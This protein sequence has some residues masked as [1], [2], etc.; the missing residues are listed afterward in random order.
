MQEENQYVVTLDDF[1]G[2]LDLLLHLV[3]EKEM[4]LVHLELNKVIEQYIQ[5]IQSFQRLNLEVASEYLVMASYLIELKSRMLIPKEEVKIEDGYQEDPREALIQR[6]IEYEKYKN[7]VSSF[8]TMKEER[9]KYYI[10]PASSLDEYVVD[11]SNA[12]PDN[13]DLYDLLKAMQKMYQRKLLSKP[14]ITNVSKKEVSIDEC[15]DD[16]RIRIKRFKKVAFEDL[17]ETMDVS[18]F[19]V[20][21][22]AILILANKNELSISQSEKFGTIYV[23]GVE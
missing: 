15:L 21:F 12:I 16:I 7:I 10:K 19:V 8:E 22:L 17:F 11:V 4:D 5:Y 1:T 6:L 3:K 2:P 18:H 9:E 13:L 23:E 14:L 20:N